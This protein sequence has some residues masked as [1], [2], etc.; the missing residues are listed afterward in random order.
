MKRFL[1]P[2]RFFQIHE[3]FFY[4]SKRFSISRNDFFIN[5]NTFSKFWKDFSINYK[6]IFSYSETLFLYSEPISVLENSLQPFTKPIHWY[7]TQNTNYKHPVSVSILYE[8]T[9][10][11]S[12]VRRIY[13]IIHLDGDSLLAAVVAG[14]VTAPA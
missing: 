11:F 3:R 8:T 12:T 6:T 2:K 4:Q 9:S 10:I 14:E 13:L 7:L 1:Y 5:Q